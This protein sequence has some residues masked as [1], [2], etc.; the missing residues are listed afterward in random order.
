MIQS[1]INKNYKGI[2]KI[3][4]HP[5]LNNI[6]VIFLIISFLIG[7]LS[8]AFF[9]VWASTDRNVANWFKTNILGQSSS[10][11]SN[12]NNSL[13]KIVKEGTIK[14]TEESAT[15]DAVKKVSPAVV[16]IIIT[17]DLSKIYNMTGPDLF[18]YDFFGFPNS[19]Q[20]PQGQQEVGAGSGFIISSDGMILTNKHVVSTQDAEYTVITS[21]GKEY[22]AK[23]LATDPFNDIALVKIEATDLPTVELGDSESLQ[24]GQTVIAIGF[25][26]GE[27]KNTVTKGVISG[28]ARTV[29]AGSSQGGQSETLEN[30]IQTDAAINFGNSGGPLINIAGQVIG[31]NTAISQEGQ[32][33]GFAIPI[34]QAKYAIESVQKEGRVIRPYL[35]VRYTIINEAIA[36]ANNLSVNYGALIVRGESRTDLAIIPGSPADKAGLVENDIILEFNGQ[37]IDQNNTLAKEI[38]KY[39]VA[40]E[41]TLKIL[42]K[43]EQKEVKITLEELK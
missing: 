27:Y 10:S 39:H 28:L 2:N 7:G 19:Y 37:K 31:V 1:E 8:G 30:I 32:L 38:Q 40:D 13:N 42:N 41:V 15:V 20:Q 9:G 25:A 36:K 17:Q 34:N 14:V 3:K 6:V 23:V 35:G 4:P 26:L 22:K 43:G 5:M 11:S 12:T 18:P 24:I 21:D 16:S 29:T 33:I